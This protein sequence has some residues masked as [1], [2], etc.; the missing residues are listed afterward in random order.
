[1]STI[2]FDVVVDLPAMI[3]AALAEGVV[4]R[5]IERRLLD[6]AIHDLRNSR[7]TVTA[8]WTTCRT[9]V[10]RNGDEARADL[11]GARRD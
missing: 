1:V 8:A 11:Q 9:A 10:G 4:G 6:V 2:T 5:A 3:E 7:P